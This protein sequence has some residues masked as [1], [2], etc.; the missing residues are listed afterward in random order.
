LA[1]VYT[2]RKMMTTNAF[3]ER[4]DRQMSLYETVIILL[5]GLGLAGVS[6]W[7]EK[8]PRTSL[9]PRLIPTTPFIFIGTLIALAAAVH[10]LRFLRV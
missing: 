4:N 7:R 8:R 6:L 5:V 1:R 3:H 9:D 2:S 10:L